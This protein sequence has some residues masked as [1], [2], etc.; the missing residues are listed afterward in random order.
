MKK[1]K[2][3]TENKKEKNKKLMKAAI[4]VLAIIIAAAV[5]LGILLF[6]KWYDKQHTDNGNNDITNSEEVDD[7]IMNKPAMP[8]DGKETQI[9]SGHV[10]VEGTDVAEVIEVMSKN[11]IYKYLEGKGFKKLET[12]DGAG[13]FDS[14]EIEIAVEFIDNAKSIE[15]MLIGKYSC[16]EETDFVTYCNMEDGV[17]KTASYTGDDNKQYMSVYKNNVLVV[18]KDKSED[19]S[20]NTTIKELFRELT[21]RREI[22]N[23]IKYDSKEVMYETERI[24]T[25]TVY[26]IG[27]D[28][29]NSCIVWFGAMPNYTAVDENGV[30]FFKKDALNSMTYFRLCNAFGDELAAIRYGKI[31]CSNEEQLQ[32]EFSALYGDI[33]HFGHEKHV[34]YST[35]DIYCKTMYADSLV[36]KYSIIPTVKRVGE[37]ET[38]VEYIEIVTSGT[39][40]TDASN[41]LDMVLFNREEIKVT[42]EKDEASLELE[43]TLAELSNEMVDTFDN[44]KEVNLFT[45]EE[46]KY[47]DI[48]DVETLNIE[49]VCTEENIE[50]VKEIVAGL[51]GVD[52]ETGEV[53]VTAGE[54]VKIYDIDK[55][56]A[57]EIIEDLEHEGIEVH[58]FTEG[59]TVEV[60]E[61]VEGEE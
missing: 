57:L 20:S 45:Y 42:C 4:I 21:S 38:T 3:K 14:P 39:S 56:G 11:N 41:R 54:L 43:L 28:E 36:Y 16:S 1:N 49:V 30:D 31:T 34:G 26:K 9:I 48:Y 55:N 33:I 32:F 8:D 25:D 24:D 23:A 50:K 53:N 46:I 13:R 40:E 59:E 51:I 47:S 29:E 52:S 15:S 12:T 18:I 17:L 6:R 19:A 7:I 10:T 61:A 35:Y 27:N 22:Y 37:N 44:S 5:V 60:E 2:E 58:A